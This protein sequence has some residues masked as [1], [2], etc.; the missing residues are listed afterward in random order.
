M[1]FATTLNSTVTS[2]EEFANQLSLS[3]NSELVEENITF[4]HKHQHELLDVLLAD[5]KKKQLYSV[6]HSS[7]T[8]IIHA[9]IELL[10]IQWD[11]RINLFESFSFTQLL[12]QNINLNILKFFIDNIGQ[13]VIRNIITLWWEEWNRLHGL[14]DIPKMLEAEKTRTRLIKL[15][16]M[17]NIPGGFMNFFLTPNNNDSQKQ[18]SFLWGCLR[19]IRYLVEKCNIPVDNLLH[20]PTEELQQ[21]AWIIR[22]LSNEYATLT[23]KSTQ[24]IDFD[25][26][27]KECP[28][29]IEQILNPYILLRLLQKS[30]NNHQ[31][32]RDLLQFLCKNEVITQYK[33]DNLLEVLHINFSDMELPWK[34]KIAK[35]P[36]S[37]E[38]GWEGPECF[39][40][41]AQIL[42]Y[43]H[44]IPLELTY[45]K[46][47]YKTAIRLYEYFIKNDSLKPEIQKARYQISKR[48][49]S[50]QIAFFNIVETLSYE[51]LNGFF[52][53]WIPHTN[54]HKRET[55]EKLNHII[56]LIK[57]WEKTIHQLIQKEEHQ[58]PIQETLNR[59]IVNYATDDEGTVTLHAPEIIPKI[60][61]VQCLLEKANSSV[62]IWDITEQL[63]S[64]YEKKLVPH[65]DNLLFVKNI[66]HRDFVKWEYS[67]L[68][69]FFS[70]TQKKY[71]SNWVKVWL[72]LEAYNS[73]IWSELRT[74]INN[75]QIE[76]LLNNEWVAYFTETELAT[77]QNSN[78][79][80][81]IKDFAIEWIQDRAPFQSSTTINRTISPLTYEQQWFNIK[82]WFQ[83]LRDPDI[84]D[85]SIK[86]DFIE[87]K[88]GTRDFA[89]LVRK[90]TNKIPYEKLKNHLP[91]IHFAARIDY[92]LKHT[93]WDVEKDEAHIKNAQELFQDIYTEFNTTSHIP[94]MIRCEEYASHFGLEFDE[95]KITKL[96][97]SLI[98][99][100]VDI[101]THYT[102]DLCAVLKYMRWCIWLKWWN[103]NA[104]LDYLLPNRFFLYTQNTT[105]QDSSIADQILT[106]LPSIEYWPIYVMDTLYWLRNK[107]ILINHIL[108][109]L[110]KSESI[111][112]QIS[113]PIFVPY[114]TITS[115]GTNEKEFIE[116][117]EQYIPNTKLQKNII[118]T[119]NMTFVWYKEFNEVTWGIIIEV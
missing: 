76:S 67:I 35:I 79:P 93:I 95:W 13:D 55:I 111:K 31:I 48:S 17:Q 9:I 49:M 102:N 30:K 103:V 3:I 4:L 60:T 92:I 54:K 77:T 39:N 50:Q 56:S 118:P 64:Y 88:N 42:H 33:C 70:E 108:A 29:A 11:A 27:W 28:F 91:L 23:G 26:Q 51:E 14:V 74:N 78:T 22:T 47:L 112:N 63:D 61:I 21:Y 40:M 25:I 109:T 15:C 32:C 44:K 114:S 97:P 52:S 45:S 84:Y 66:S 96:N 110:K 101:I 119:I 69:D 5:D 115:A 85:E 86:Q 65:I 106:I 6:L 12:K 58:E 38:L 59:F 75:P 68:Y 43:T 98:R 1:D 8:P 73:N 71:I 87:A 41:S 53:Y 82:T 104:N 83:E 72:V 57:I 37:A 7:H 89:A 20:I 80:T 19:E 100:P 90:L 46:L 107:D 34:E 2:L 10:D 62:S 16:C 24:I 105:S 36:F 116:H 113:L 18:I 94:G 99:L 81:L 117:L